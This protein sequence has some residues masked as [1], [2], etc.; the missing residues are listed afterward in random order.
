M[1]TAMSTKNR[2]PDPTTKCLDGV[3]AV[4]GAVAF[5]AHLVARRRPWGLGL[6]GSAAY[7]RESVEKKLTGV[8]YECRERL[9]ATSSCAR[10]VRTIAA[11]TAW[12]SERRAQAGMRGGSGIA[13][14]S[15]RPARGRGE[16]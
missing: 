5:M 6:M 3:A 16:R 9:R 4:A 1:R 15:H 12:D 11:R 10:A 7:K 8:D 2:D 14:G 13:G